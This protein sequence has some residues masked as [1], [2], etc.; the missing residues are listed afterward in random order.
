MWDITHG[1]LAKHELKYRL[2]KC[3]CVLLAI[4]PAIRPAYRKCDSG[5][6]PKIYTM[7]KT[8]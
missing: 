4:A 7:N 1:F 8:Y 5:A 2:E 6:Y 3:R